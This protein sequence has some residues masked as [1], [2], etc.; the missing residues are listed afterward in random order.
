[1][2][3]PRELRYRDGKLWQTPVRE[4]E[5]LREEELHWPGQRLRCAGA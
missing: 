4:L 3:C 1:M 2:T 5:M